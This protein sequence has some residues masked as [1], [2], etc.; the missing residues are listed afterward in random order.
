MTK[1]NSN[2]SFFN[3][4]LKLPVVVRMKLQICDF[5]KWNPIIIYQMGK[6]GSSSV[7]RIL[8]GANLDRPVYHV[9]FLSHRGIANAEKYFL[10]LNNSGTPHHIKLSK[11]LR[12]KI[13]KSKDFR[14][15][16]ITLVRE[17]VAR[18]VSDC[19]QNLESYHP[20]LID[21]KGT[22]KKAKIIQLLENHFR[23]Y[24]ANKD[25]T[26]NWFDNELRSTFE[27]DVYKYPFNFQDG[28]SLITANNIDLLVLRLENLDSTF[29][30]AF[31]RFLDSNIS[32]NMYRS[33]V[34]QNK[35][36]SATYRY[37][38]ENLTLPYK[39][40]EKIYSSKYASHFYTQI[41]RNNFISQWSCCKA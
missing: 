19:F 34:G 29:N 15:K 23:A 8:K 14:W 16:V 13:C 9:H 32:F 28:F 2:S 4:L 30:R 39:I 12:K 10:S 6:V 36:Y 26:A 24:D 40:C 31:N 17:P 22:A 35:R 33:N 5:S 7:E 27:L 18:D 41:E 38:L 21:R 3:R 37:L 11:I 20:H 25:Y 1:G